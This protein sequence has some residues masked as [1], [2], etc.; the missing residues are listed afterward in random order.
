MNF[1]HCLIC[2]SPLKESQCSGIIDDKKWHN[3]HIRTY[4]ISIDYGKYY[5]DWYLDSKILEVSV[6]GGPSYSLNDFHINFET[7]NIK[8]YIDRIELYKFYS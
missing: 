7:F 8:D 4:V 5:T 6:S 2:R 3:F 1:T